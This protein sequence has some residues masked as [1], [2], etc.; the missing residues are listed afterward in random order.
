[1]GRI[2]PPIENVVRNSLVAVE[3][4]QPNII[5]FGRVLIPWLFRRSA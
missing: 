4:N 3:C 2:A 5:I 1:M